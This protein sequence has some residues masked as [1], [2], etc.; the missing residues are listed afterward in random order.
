MID[1][2][3]ASVEYIS[4]EVTSNV[5]LDG[6]PSVGFT[7]AGEMPTEATTWSYAEWAGSERTRAGKFHRTA[8]L[9]VGGPVTSEPLARK[10]DSGKYTM[11]L[12]LSDTP[13]QIVRSAGTIEV[14]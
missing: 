13:E 9:L 10:L 5:E 8:Q 11:W 4:W 3:S 14:R 12:K 2:Q 1:F 7:P 6:A